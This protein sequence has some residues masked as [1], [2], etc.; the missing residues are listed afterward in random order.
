MGKKK[1]AELDKQKEN[2]LNGA[3]LK[4]NYKRRAN[5]VFTKI[6]YLRN[7]VLIKVKKLLML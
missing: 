3:I 6:D 5:F 1:K 2:F 7:T 4:R